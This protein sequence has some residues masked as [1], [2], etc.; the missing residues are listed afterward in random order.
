VQTFIRPT[1]SVRSAAIS[2]E[3]PAV[4]SLALACA[5][6]TTVLAAGSAPASARGH[7]ALPARCL[8]T[9]ARLKTL[10]DPDRRRVRLQPRIAAIPALA[11][12]TA[13][14]PVPRRRSTLF[15]RQAWRVVAQ[16]VQFRLGADGALELVL[17]DGGA[18][19][20]AGMPSPAC[21]G[22]ASRARRA[23]LATRAQFVST[24]GQP[25]SEWQ[26]LGAVG[27]IS[28]VGY[29]SGLSQPQAALN[30]AELQPVTSLRLIAGC[31]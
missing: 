20:R 31:R 13:P 2:G 11:G 23:V 16:I 1:A 26:P 27:Y 24:C 15:Q 25:R 29:W 17:F 5:A 4:V 30:G 6:S 10:S 14:R 22:R 3:R 18:Y 21:I 9:V 12:L 7:L 28:G 19:V 8:G